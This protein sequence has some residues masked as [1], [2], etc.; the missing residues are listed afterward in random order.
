MCTLGRIIRGER[1]ATKTELIAL[2]AVTGLKIEDLI[3]DRQEE[4]QAS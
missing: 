3:I 1:E 2:N 4:D